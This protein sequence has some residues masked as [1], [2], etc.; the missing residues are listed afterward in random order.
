MLIAVD[1]Y[2]RSTLVFALKHEFDV[3]VRIKQL[4]AVIKRETDKR[5]EHVWTG[6]S[7][8]FYS[9]L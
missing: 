5:I 2:L 6:S 4:R 1:N 8:E 9:R 3:V 7:I